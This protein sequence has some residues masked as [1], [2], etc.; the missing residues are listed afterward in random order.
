MGSDK[1]SPQPSQ[2]RAFQLGDLPEP[3]LSAV[4]NH[5]EGCTRCET[6]AQSL[7]GTLDSGARPDLEAEMQSVFSRPWTH[8]FVQSHKDKEVADR[9]TVGHRG[10]PIGVVEGIRGDGRDAWLRFR[11]KRPLERHDGPTSK[12]AMD[13]RTWCLQKIAEMRA[14]ASEKP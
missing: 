8:L 14:A 11:T 3:D 5:L 1:E 6:R 2:L 13:G 9:D 7:D 12:D 4:A 10:T